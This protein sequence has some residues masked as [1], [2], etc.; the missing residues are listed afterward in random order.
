MTLTQMANGEEARA[1]IYEIKFEDSRYGI[2]NKTHPTHDAGQFKNFKLEEILAKSPNDFAFGF[3]PIIKN[4]AVE[5][6]ER[7][8]QNRN[9]NYPNAY[10][11]SASRNYFS[12]N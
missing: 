4:Y 12:M 11:F 8:I 1:V 3:G 9:A 7:S 10:S 6:L 2:V 5:L